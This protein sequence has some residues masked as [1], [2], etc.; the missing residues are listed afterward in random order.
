MIDDRELWHN[1]G[2]ITKISPDKQGYMDAFIL[3]ARKSNG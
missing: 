2:T 3:T 1:A